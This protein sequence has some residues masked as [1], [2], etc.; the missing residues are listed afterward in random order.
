MA[1]PP[2]AVPANRAAAMT[3]TLFCWNMYVM[4]VSFQ[5][6]RPSIVLR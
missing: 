5:P 2:I 6:F 4:V 3:P 1:Q